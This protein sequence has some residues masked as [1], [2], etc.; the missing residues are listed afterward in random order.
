MYQYLHLSEMALEDH[1]GVHSRLD[2]FS[3]FDLFFMKPD[4]SNIQCN[5]YLSISC[6]K[7]QHN[8]VYR[9]QVQ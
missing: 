7:I 9:T 8:V 4:G 2:M 6:K 3:N 1:L 5:S